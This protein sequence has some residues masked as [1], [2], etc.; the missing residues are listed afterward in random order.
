MSGYRWLI[1]SSTVP[2]LGT[3]KIAFDLTFPLL[4]ETIKKFG[5][6]KKTKIEIPGESRGIYNNDKEKISLLSL[7]NL[8]F[9]QGVA[10]TAIQMLTAYA[11]IANG[12][13][14][15]Q[16]TIVKSIDG[17]PIKRK[18]GKRII[19]EDIALE[20]QKMLMAVVEE[21]TAQNI[22]M[23]YFKIAGKTGTAQRADESGS[24]SGYIPNF[25]G[26]SS[27]GAQEI[28]SCTLI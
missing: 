4:D 24:Y 18:E 1:L 20:L 28:L 19:A 7:S 6:G 10:T 26:F 25:V 12:G 8:S 9:G 16:P 17:E 13:V 2:T 5:F 11:A 22:K 14:Y 15:Y 23:P 21:G 27:R 3:V